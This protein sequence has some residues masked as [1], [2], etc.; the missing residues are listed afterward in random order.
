MWLKCGHPAVAKLTWKVQTLCSLTFVAF[1]ITH[2]LCAGKKDESAIGPKRGK[3]CSIAES[4]TVSVADHSKA[5]A[6]DQIL[7]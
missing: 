2:T 7:L 3:G 1:L 5:C 4:K 6:G